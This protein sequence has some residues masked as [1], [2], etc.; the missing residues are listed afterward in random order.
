MNFNNITEIVNHYL[1]NSCGACYSVCKQEAIHYYETVG[2]YVFPRVDSAKCIDCSLCIEVCQGLKFGNS[3]MNYFPRYDP[4]V[5]K[6]IES[7]VGKAID[8]EIY[9]NS[10]SGG[11]VTA[12]LDKLLKSGE[13]N[14]AIVTVMKKGV[15]PRGDYAIA[16]DRQ[17]LL[18]SQKSKYSPIPLLKAIKEIMKIKGKFAIVGLGCH[19]QGLYNLFDLYPTLKEKIFIIIGLVCDRVMTTTAIDFLIERYVG[20]EADKFIFRDKN[21]PS[22]P[23]NVVIGT[24]GNDKIIL[25][26]T[27]RM[28]IKDFFTPARCWICFDKMNVF[29]DIT[30][31]DPH[32]VEGV[33]RIGGESAVIVRTE[34]GK[35][36]L[37]SA[38]S[39]NVIRM[40]HVLQEEI[41]SG[42]LINE[43]KENWYAFIQLWDKRIGVRP[44]YASLIELEKNKIK[45]KHHNLLKNAFRLNMFKSRQAVIRHYGKKVI[46]NK[47]KKKFLGRVNSLRRLLSLLC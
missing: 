27:D 4:F 21:E 45:K 2:G 35:S 16:V 28:E 5:G 34:K 44:T 46:M 11:I 19:I 3:L 25:D 7:F 31:C 13:I 36:I 23:G 22:Y 14:A 47:L 32:G 40:R 39:N 30:V 18:D 1:C 6:I 38:M 9:E 29:S 15:P 26:S 17:G 37:D 33:D 20:K 43:K 24:V 42:Q 8:N 10:Q 41:L 12:L